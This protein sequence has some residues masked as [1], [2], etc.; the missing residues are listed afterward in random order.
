M[1]P[2]GRPHNNPWCKHQY[3]T[4]I[5]VSLNGNS[6]LLDNGKSNLTTLGQLPFY[7]H[8]CSTTTTV[9]QNGKP[10]KNFPIR[11][12]AQPQH[13]RFEKVT[14][15]SFAIVF[16]YKTYKICFNPTFTTLLQHNS[17]FL[18]YIPHLCMG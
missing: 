7:K 18:M 11:R 6:L 17:P 14:L 9:N 5:P 8:F 4:T 15:V 1:N 2:N 3:S 16:V 12:I 13:Q 10:N